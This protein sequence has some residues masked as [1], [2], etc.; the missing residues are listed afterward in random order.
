MNL[1]SIVNSAIK[2]VNPDIS[3]TLKRSTGFTVET[4]GKQTPTYSTLTGMIQVQATSGKDLEHMNNLNIQGVFRTVYLLGNWAGVVR[5][6][7]K[8]GDIM[9]FPQIPGGT[10]HNWKVINVKETWPD[11][12]SV[13][14]VLQ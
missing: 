2:R 8:G 1:H 14:V 12:S 10:V 11:W 3:A 4:N 13:I 7:S 5:T 9:S 6:D